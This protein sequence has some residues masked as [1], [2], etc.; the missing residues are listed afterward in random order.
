MVSCSWASD[1]RPQLGTPG[2]GSRDPVVQIG[3]ESIS[4]TRA[5]VLKDET[6]AAIA[7]KWLAKESIVY[8]TEVSRPW[9][10]AV[11]VT[12]SV[13]ISDT[14]RILARAASS[15]VARPAPT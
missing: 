9:V 1:Y 10:A 13:S 4:L 14:P 12:F 15:E 7:G 3:W 8:T 11:R 5:A 6:D 2:P